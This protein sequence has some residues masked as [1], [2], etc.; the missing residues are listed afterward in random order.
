MKN[1]FIS[2]FLLASWVM[3]S[4]IVETNGRLV[5][6]GNKICGEKTD[7]EP[8]Q[9]KGPSFFWSTPGWGGDLFFRTETVNAMVDSWNATLVRAPLGVEPGKMEDESATGTGYEDK[10]EDNWA[11]VETVID[12]AIAKGIYVIADW[13][14]HYAHT[15]E[16]LAID[17]FTNENRAGKYCNTE[18][19]IYEIFNEPLDEGTAAW[20]TIKTYANNVIAAIRNKGCNNLILVGTPF[21]SSEVDVAANDPPTDS[22]NNFA[23]VFHMYADEHRIDK[24]PWPQKPAGTTYGGLVQAALDKGFP[25]FVSEWGTNNAGSGAPNLAEADKWV[26][27]MDEN[28]ISWAIWS[29]YSNGALSLWNNINPLA[30][31]EIFGANAFNWTNPNYMSVNGRYVYRLLTGKDTTVTG[32]AK[33]QWMEYVGD[34]SP[35]DKND[36]GYYAWIQG[37]DD[38]PTKNVENGAGFIFE[39]NLTYAGFGTG[40]D[41]SLGLENCGYGI[42]YSYRGAAH[43][44]YITA[45]ATVTSA[46]AISEKSDT[47]K[48]VN[49][50][51]S[52]FLGHNTSNNSSI[53]EI[54]WNVIMASANKTK[55][56][57]QIKDLICLEDPNG[58][59]LS[60]RTPQIANSNIRAYSAGKNI[61]LANVPANA[62]IEVYNLSG[63]KIYN[64]Q[65]STL[66]SQLRIEVQTKGMYLVRVNAQTL[67]VAVF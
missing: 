27:F 48:S 37:N 45:T 3:A 54:G 62:K 17:Y 10:Q 5:R 64:S 59:T 40:T 32:P 31:D 11:L 46:R 43:E 9:V 57:L 1:V 35:I 42:G 52:Y 26:K 8:V 12:A 13:H 2:L 29:V 7:G 36:W 14:S 39:G 66:N 28:K 53:N 51:W 19:V 33:I 61:M 21:Y 50:K 67:R 6:C 44:F 22:E 49:H 55:D 65:L 20:A 15:L 63:K 34:S 16:A 18:N 25:V 56:S 41:L 24:A 30:L 4:N 60:I 58:G 23:F 47:W 38:H